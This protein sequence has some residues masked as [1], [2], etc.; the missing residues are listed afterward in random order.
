MLKTSFK[1]AVFLIFLGIFISFVLLEIS[2]RSGGFIFTVHQDKKNQEALGEDKIIVLCIGESTTALGGEDSYPSQ[3]Q[4]VLNKKIK[5]KEFR[6]INKGIVSSTSKNIANNIKGWLVKYKPNIV[7]SMVGVNDR[8]KSLTIEKPSFTFAYLFRNLRVYKLFKMSA[9]KLDEK[10]RGVSIK[11]VR[12]IPKEE[13]KDAIKSILRAINS[14]QE[15]WQ[16]LK[17][18]VDSKDK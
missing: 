15:L 16:D 4:E 18:I 3:L 9:L 5:G 2:L 8:Y 1:N 10:K 17:N 14:S 11:N 12:W 13:K 7:I 6:V